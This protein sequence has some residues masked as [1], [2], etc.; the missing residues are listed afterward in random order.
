M[1]LTT[2]MRTFV[3]YRSS[4]GVLTY[5]RRKVFLAL[6]LLELGQAERSEQVTGFTAT[7]LIIQILIFYALVLPRRTSPQLA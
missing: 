7:Y 6:S 1:S 4:G 3:V 2:T 5:V